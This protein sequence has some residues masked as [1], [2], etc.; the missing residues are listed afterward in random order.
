MISAL[1]INYNCI[2]NNVFYT[3]KPVHKGHSREPENVAFMSSYI[4]VKIIFAIH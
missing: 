2:V 3:I 1:L 4:Q